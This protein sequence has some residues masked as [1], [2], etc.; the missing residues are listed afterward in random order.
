MENTN[1]N[2]IENNFY[3][4]FESKK[5]KLWIAIIIS[6]IGIVSNYSAIKY[7]LSHTRFDLIYYPNLLDFYAIG[8]TILL[9]SSIVLFSLMRI[10]LLTWCS[11][12]VAL[13]I[14]IYANIQLMFQVAGG[15]TFKNTNKLFDDPSFTLTFIVSMS[16]AILP[17][18]ILKQLMLLLLE[19]V[20]KENGI[21]KN[22][23]KENTNYEWT[24]IN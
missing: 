19:Q 14:S 7:Q 4:F 23:E 6:T 3:N 1:T 22:E 15:D 10:N 17:I 24:K 9:D 20:D 2:I 13:I 18:I 8:I 5:L 16:F 12:I 21:F 11:T